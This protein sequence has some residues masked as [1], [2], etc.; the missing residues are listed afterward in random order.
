MLLPIIEGEYVNEYLNGGSQVNSMKKPKESKKCTNCSQPASRQSSCRG[1]APSGSCDFCV[2]CR[3]DGVADDFKSACV[4]SIS[5][6]FY[7]CTDFLLQ[8]YCCHCTTYECGV[9]P[10]RH[11]VRAVVRTSDRQVRFCALV[12]QWQQQ[13][14]RILSQSTR[15]KCPFCGWDN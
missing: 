6:K 14:E 4:R 7:F 12:L 8:Y 9:S 10:Q 5:S 3:R 1:A 2:A 15:R 13:C 11:V